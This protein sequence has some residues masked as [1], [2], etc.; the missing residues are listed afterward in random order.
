MSV[1][2]GDANTKLGTKMNLILTVLEIF[3][4]LRFARGQPV[5]MPG[6]DPH[7][8]TTGAGSQRR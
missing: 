4:I 2:A 7:V 6:Y 8:D 3:F 1:D 5:E